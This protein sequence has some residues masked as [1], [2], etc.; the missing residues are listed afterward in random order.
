MS[1]AQR[2]GVLDRFLSVWILLIMAVGLLVGYFAPGVGDSLRSV[3]VGSVALP[4]ALGLILMLLPVFCKV[5]YEELRTVCVCVCVCVC[6]VFFKRVLLVA[7]EER[8]WD[9]AT[10]AKS[11]FCLLTVCCLI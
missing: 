11:G 4:V 8:G 5:P 2:L 10:C 3:S 7:L 9:R 1:L 6:V